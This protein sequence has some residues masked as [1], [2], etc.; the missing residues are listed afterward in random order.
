MLEV[1]YS[2]KG[3]AFDSR[4][5]TTVT[6]RTVPQQPL[7]TNSCGLYT[8]MYALYIAE[9]VEMN[10]KESDMNYFRRFIASELL[11]GTYIFVFM[12][13]TRSI[14]TENFV[15]RTPTPPPVSDLSEKRQ[16]PPSKFKCGTAKGDG[17]CF[18]R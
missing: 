4:D 10:F 12:L 6:D 7:G 16:V 11:K 13:Y 1:I 8:L 9:G 3:V 18:F 5:W 2:A 14:F 17:N 15:F